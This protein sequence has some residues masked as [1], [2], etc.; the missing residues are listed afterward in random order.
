MEFNSSPRLWYSLLLETCDHFLPLLMCL[1]LM[2]SLTY[3]LI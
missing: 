2:Y 1:V 3:L